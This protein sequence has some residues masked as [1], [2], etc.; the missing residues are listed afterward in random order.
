MLQALLQSGTFQD[1]AA[2]VLSALT[3][4]IMIS[5]STDFSYFKSQLTK[6]LKTKARE[7]LLS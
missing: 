6:H 5:N 7:K 2:S 1:S 3:H 4:P